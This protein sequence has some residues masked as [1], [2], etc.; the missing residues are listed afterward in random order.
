MIKRRRNRTQPIILLRIILPGSL[1]RSGQWDLRTDK[2]W[3]VLA[4]KVDISC[5]WKE[6]DLG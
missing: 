3:Q 4:A 1:V 5:F 6:V 2:A